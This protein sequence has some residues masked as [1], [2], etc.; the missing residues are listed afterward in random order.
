M[1]IDSKI[2]WTHHT[3]NPGTGCQKVSV[4]CTNCYA[5]AIRARFGHTDEWGPEGVRE[6]TGWGTWK[7]PLKRHRELCDLQRAMDETAEIQRLLGDPLTLVI[8]QRVELER[9]FV[10][11][12]CDIFEDHPAVAQWRMG[13]WEMMIHAHFHFRWLLLTKRPENIAEMLPDDFDGWDR[14]RV[15]GSMWLGTSIESMDYAW[16]RD[17]LVKVP[18]PVHFLSIEPMLG[19]VHDLDLTDIEWVIVGGES[20]AGYRDDI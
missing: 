5:E 12:L 1:G 15:A 6:L 17:E 16:R 20:G 9:V 10:G 7:K 13:L 18:A 14:G 3:L 11:S 19:P 2:G 8:G 4:G